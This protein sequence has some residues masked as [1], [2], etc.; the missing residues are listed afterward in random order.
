MAQPFDNRKLELAGDAVPVAERVSFDTFSASATGVLV[1]GTGALR[2][3]QPQQT[4]KAPNVTVQ[5]QLTWFDRQGKVV[6]IVGEPGAY[7]TLSLS[8]DNTKLAFQRSIRE[9]DR[10]NTDVWVHEFARGIT[11]RLTSDPAVTLAPVCNGDGSRIAFYSSRNPPGIYQRASN[12]GGEDQLLLK[13]DPSLRMFPSAQGWSRDGRFMLLYSVPP[14]SGLGPDADLWVLP[15][16]GAG[17]ETGDRKAVPL[18]KTEFAE[19]GGRFSPDGRW[20][21][22]TSDK[23]GKDEA[24][25]RAFDPAFVPGSGNPSPGGENIVSKDGGASPHWR[26]DGR[27]IFYLAPDGSV[28]AVDITTSPEFK[29]GVPKRLFKVPPGV[30]Y[31]DVA[32]DGKSFLIPVA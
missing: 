2:L 8:L 20:F 17:S 14:G 31:W 3:P 21:S 10:G 16:G 25:V 5:G 4:G 9:N 28:M 32:N 23:S 1:Y 30:I 27:E 29:A 12:G 13:T 26:G 7:T 19:R 6:S 11:T 15:L 24:Y 22:Y 18:L